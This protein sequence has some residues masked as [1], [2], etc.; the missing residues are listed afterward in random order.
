MDNIFYAIMN[1]SIADVQAILRRSPGS[2]NQTSNSGVDLNAQDQNGNTALHFAVENNDIEMAKLLIDAGSDKTVKNIRGEKPRDIV[3]SKEMNDTLNATP[4]D[5]S[6]PS[7][8]YSAEYYSAIGPELAQLQHALP[9]DVNILK[10]FALDLVQKQAKFENRCREIIYQLVEEKHILAHKN[11]LMEEAIGIKDKDTS[12]RYIEQLQYWQDEN[13]RNQATITYLKLRLQEKETNIHEQ[14][15]QSRLQL[16]QMSKEHALQLSSVLEK[17]EET[18]RALQD[19]QKI[20]TETQT[21][22]LVDMRKSISQR[23]AQKTVESLNSEV[24]VLQEELLSCTSQNSALEERLKLSEKLL[25]LKEKENAVLREDL[26]QL[27]E[28]L[29]Q[30]A[31]EKPDRQERLNFDARS[32]AVALEA[33]PRNSMQ[34]KAVPVQVLIDRL[35]D[36]QTHDAEFVHAFILTHKSFMRSQELMRELSK[37][38]L[39]NASTASTSSPRLLRTI[40]TLK[41]WI[42]NYW[43]DF[44]EDG[45][46]LADLTETMD[47]LSKTD[48]DLVNMV[49]NITSRKLQATTSHIRKSTDRPCPKP[50]LPKGLQKRYEPEGT[51]YKVNAGLATIIIPERIDI[52]DRSLQMAQTPPRLSQELG[53]SLSD[54]TSLSREPKPRW[55]FA[56]FDPLEVARQITLIEFELFSAIKPREFLDLAWMKDDKEKLAPNI[57]KM[58][59]WSNHVVRWLITEIVTIKDQPKIR[60]AAYERVARVAKHLA[61]LNNFN[62]VKEC[63][64]ALQSSSVYRLRKTKASVAGKY[65]KVV[66][67]LQRMISSELNYKSLRSRIHA[68]EPPVIPF[69]GIYQ[70]DLV[71]LDTT[72][73]SAPSDGNI[74]FV[75]HLK[76]FQYVREIQIYQQ[77]SYALTPIPE[78]QEYIKAFIGMSDDDAY[79]ASLA[80]EPR[81]LTSSRGA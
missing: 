50:I 7:Q 63:V 51:V 2:I 57:M 19:L 34:L 22:K 20:Y 73:K 78:I 46:L 24:V 80:C 61:V 11:R 74:N 26:K 1:G 52:R 38:A 44:Q 43:S 67:E 5:D 33:V 71:F 30:K 69:P 81:E 72:N 18:Q 14:I 48:P 40:N 36:P 13:E 59:R 47:I 58:A 60:A 28:S 15:E 16:G 76:V 29:T 70:G 77:T 53:G 56:D 64:A 41:Y 25:D 55:L 17:H 75:K 54:I 9:S 3:K 4:C 66:E 39:G 37:A 8:K 23:Q 68:A 62:G 6:D 12:T 79:D 27:R 32:G 42:E 65:I 10:I 21:S 35:T 45:Q 31:S 49:R